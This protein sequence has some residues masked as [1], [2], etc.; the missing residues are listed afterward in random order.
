[1][2]H[3]QSAPTRTKLSTQTFR[4]KAAQV[5]KQ[6][7]F[8]V[9]KKVMVRVLSRPISVDIVILLYNDLCQEYFNF[10]LFAETLLGSTTAQ[11]G[12]IAQDDC[13]KF[14][15][16]RKEPD[17]FFFAADW[18]TSVLY[19]LGFFFSNF[20]LSGV[21]TLLRQFHRLSGVLSKF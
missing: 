10:A 7:L 1:M 14:F 17:A 16:F 11:P 5:Q 9:G 6:F 18:L 4:A 21:N 13:S 19:I 3:A 2:T 8:A 12:S 15:I 20:M